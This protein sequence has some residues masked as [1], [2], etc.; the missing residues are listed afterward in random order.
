MKEWLSELHGGASVEELESEIAAMPVDEAAERVRSLGRQGGEDVVSLLERVARS[1]RLQLAESAVHALGDV[2]SEAAAQALDELA[3]TADHK[4]LQKAARR[5]IYRLS[6]QGIRLKAR[7]VASAPLAYSRQA[8]LY[9]VIAS[10]FDG[11]GTR[12]LWFGAERSMGGIYLIA[13]VIND[14]RGLLDCAARD[15][16]RKRFAE[17][18]AAMREK[19]P[20]GWV[21][22]PEE[23]AR[24]LVG[25]SV[26][27]ARAA[28]GPVPPAYPLWADLI[29]KP[30]QPF[31]QAMIYEQ[32][33]GFEA[34]MHPTLQSESPRLFDEPEV[35]SWFFPPDEVRKWVE[36][37]SRPLASRLI[38]IPETDR[39]RQE[40]LVRGAI[41]ELLPARE[42]KGLR[43]RLEETAYIFLRTGRETQARRAVAAAAT[44]EEERPL[45]APHPFLR[46]L[47]ERSI[48]IARQVDRSGVEPVRLARMP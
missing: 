16:T 6:S 27:N 35:E 44:I 31:E 32:I 8:T 28:G 26:E 47:V 33:S 22:L 11:A 3:R 2:R 14:V 4:A 19:D 13:V 46:A 18:E 21:E 39:E 15:T 17:R 29:D 40:R 43:R 24:Q 7:P 41:A 23:Y 5:A 38:V 34:R 36:E 48:A 10:S 1:S 45:Q 37:L 20:M 9:R 30:A 42:R 25:E 12:S